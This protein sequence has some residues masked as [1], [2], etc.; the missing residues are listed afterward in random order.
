MLN[1]LSTGRRTEKGVLYKRLLLTSGNQQIFSKEVLVSLSN[2]SKSKHGQF[3]E[4]VFKTFETF[5]ISSRFIKGRNGNGKI[6]RLNLIRTSDTYL[7]GTSTVG[8]SQTGRFVDAA[9]S[10]YKR[11]SN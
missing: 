6:L 11:N 8:I 10:I 1:Q 3:N 2:T 9:L 5:V 4:I 7:L